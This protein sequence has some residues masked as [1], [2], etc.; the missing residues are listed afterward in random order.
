MN[1]SIDHTVTAFDDDLN[2]LAE[3]ISTMGGQAEHSVEQSVIALTKG[4]TSLA[5]TLIAEDTILDNLQEQLDDRAVLIIA[6]RQPMAADL[7]EIIGAIRIG[8]DLERIGDLA[9]NIARRTL[10]I[11]TVAPPKRLIRGL[12]SLTEQTL[13]QLHDG[14]DC[15]TEKNTPKAR[16][17]WQKDD[18]IDA[19]YTSLFREL[20]TYMMEDPRLITTCTHLLFCAK[21]IERIGDHVSNIAETVSY[22]VEGHSQMQGGDPA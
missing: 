7:R 5:K 16:S 19:V 3:K 15:F 12:E 14:L 20:L 2:F 11:D 22:I 4:D 18:Q 8:I 9:T 21:N 13:H 1:H 6:K 10:A 17:V